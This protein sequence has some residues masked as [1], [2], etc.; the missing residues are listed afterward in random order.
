[1]KLLSSPTAL[2]IETAGLSEMLT[3]TY[4]K[5]CPHI[6]KGCELKLIDYYVGNKV[7]RHRTFSVF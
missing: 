7:E 2:Q 5:A 1:M 4:P 3:L 6:A